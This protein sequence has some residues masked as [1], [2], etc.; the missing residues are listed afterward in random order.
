MNALGA[1]RARLVKWLVAAAYPLWSQN[2]IDPGNG[3]FAEALDGNG[4]AIALP[5]RARVHPRQVY[6]FSQARAFGW[7]GDV[8]GIVTRGI[9]YFERH[10]RRTDGLFR[11]MTDANGAALD[12]R[13]L[14]YDQAF[15]LLGYAAAAAALGARAEFETRAL[16]LR[17]TIEAHLRMEDG[18]YH[19]LEGSAGHRESNPH[20][21]LLEAYLAW[22]EIGQDAGWAAGVRAI[23]ELALSRFI[24]DSGAIGESYLATWQPAPGMAGRLVEPGHQFEWAWLLL[25]CERWHPA[26]ALRGAALRL[27]SIG[28]RFGVRNGVAIDAMYDDFSIKDARARLWPQTER[29]KAALLAAALTGEAHYEAMAEAAVMSFFPYLDAAV[30]GLWRD[31][32]LPNGEFIGSPV[33]A[34][35]FYHL[36]SAIAALDP[37]RRPSVP[38]P[39]PGPAHRPA[40]GERTKRLST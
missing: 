5:R 15:A 8:T 10:Y 18:A 26:P 12:E 20:M 6:A 36:V 2:G 23:A 35:T 25:R 4:H 24:R 28:E 33:P 11:T 13:A 38:Q 32:R 34:S 22:A 17:H 31:V 7:R 40:D 37:A 39:A 1:P 14:L 19:S 3:G 9:E 29:L 16:P 30:S 27:I 21:H